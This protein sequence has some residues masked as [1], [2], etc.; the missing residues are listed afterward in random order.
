LEARTH[1]VEKSHAQEGPRR[2]GVRPLLTFFA[3]LGIIVISA[4]VAG[5]LPRLRRG[6]TLE[7]A[8]STLRTQRPVVKVVAALKAPASG[9]LDLPGDLQALIESPIFARAD[10]YLVKRN[11]DIGDRVK[12]GQVMAEIETP[13]LD[14]QLAQAQATLSNSRSALAELQADLVLAEANLKLAEKTYQRWLNLEKKGVVSHQDADERSANLDVQRAQ[15]TAAHAKIVSAND[16]VAANEASLHR[17]EQMKLF[18]K[19]TAP[20]DGLITARNVDVGT[21]INY[22]NG[23]SKQEM[24]RV[25]DIGT[26]RVFVNIPQAYAGSVEVDQKAELRVQELPGQVFST[27]VKRF[28]H[29]VDAASRSMLAILVVP[30]PRG[31]L[32]PGM[33]AQVRFT[34]A[35]TAPALLIPSDALILSPQGTRVATVDAAGKV[36]FRDIQVGADSGSQVEVM[37]GLSEGDRIILNPTDAIRDGVAVDVQP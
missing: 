22:G 17:L 30:N 14:Q 12:N 1:A 19:V 13:E 24:F 9:S 25:A 35:R 28:T 15:V 33:Y 16:F 4:V 23:G 8:A 3:V 29:E 26:M 20:F 2:R 18:S 37:A 10:G 27:V 34:E 21:L 5:W 31:I 7:A 36:R 11:V 32:L 6:R